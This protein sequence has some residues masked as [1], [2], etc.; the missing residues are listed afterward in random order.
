MFHTFLSVTKTEQG[1]ETF[2]LKGSIGM[3][4]LGINIE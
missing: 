4:K 3:N 1:K 2:S